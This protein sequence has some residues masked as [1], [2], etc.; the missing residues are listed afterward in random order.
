[1]N[2]V[3]GRGGGASAVVGLFWSEFVVAILVKG[4]R[5]LLGGWVKERVLCWVK[6]GEKR[7]N[8]YV[9]G[10]HCLCRV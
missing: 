6:D 4:E 7:C 9:I 1:M 2:A 3:G 8:E 10:C 5:L